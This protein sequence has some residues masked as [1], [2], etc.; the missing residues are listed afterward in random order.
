MRMQLGMTIYTDISKTRVHTLTKSKSGP[1]YT[2]SAS[3]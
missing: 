3:V 2:E 1:G